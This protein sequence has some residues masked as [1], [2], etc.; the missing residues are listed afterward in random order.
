MASALK[1]IIQVRDLCRSV[2]VTS[3]IERLTFM[4]GEATN[5]SGWFNMFI[6]VQAK[7]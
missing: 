7:F 1:P 5:L 4:M 2:S 3:G 6:A